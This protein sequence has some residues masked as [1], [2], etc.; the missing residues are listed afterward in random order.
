[1]KLENE[2]MIKWEYDKALTRSD[3]VSTILVELSDKYNS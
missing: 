1:V 2:E 3:G